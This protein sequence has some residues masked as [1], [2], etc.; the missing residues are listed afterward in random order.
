M[1][2]FPESREDITPGFS[3]PPLKDRAE[4]GGAIRAIVKAQYDLDEKSL[5]F[6]NPIPKG[7]EFAFRNG[8]IRASEIPALQLS[9]A[10]PHL[11]K[12]AISSFELEIQRATNSRV[13]LSLGARIRV[14]HNDYGYPSAEA[15]MDFGFLKT[16][17]EN[18]VTV[19]HGP[20]KDIKKVRAEINRDLEN[21]RRQER[22]DE[23]QERWARERRN[24]NPEGYGAWNKYF[25]TVSVDTIQG[26]APGLV[27]QRRIRKR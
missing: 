19:S 22:R 9:W 12:T 6:S 11:Q 27:Q 1:N 4:V 2:R 13:D 26:G 24:D 18:I 20:I 25:G 8:V 15:R 3:I 16:P 5:R 7:A 17:G 10:R 21:L 23:Q 14:V